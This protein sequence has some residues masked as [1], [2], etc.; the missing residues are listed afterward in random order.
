[1]IKRLK[2]QHPQEEQAEEERQRGS[3]VPGGGGGPLSRLMKEQQVLPLPLLVCWSLLE[4]SLA[5]PS[6]SAGASRH[7]HAAFLWRPCSHKDQ[8]A[9]SFSWCPAPTRRLCSCSC[10][11][12]VGQEVGLREGRLFQETWTRPPSGE[13]V[14][15]PPHHLL[16]YPRRNTKVRTRSPSRLLDQPFVSDQRRHR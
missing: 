8:H 16:L 15:L 13:S 9:Y 1:M 12:M 5:N 10:S 14:N 7:E 4:G 3:E 11:P 2:S 6:V